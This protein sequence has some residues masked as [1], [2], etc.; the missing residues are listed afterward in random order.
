MPKFNVEVSAQ[1]IATGKWRLRVESEDE[2]T[3]QAEAVS[4]IALLLEAN[5]MAMET[6]G[7]MFKVESIDQSSIDKPANIELLTDTVELATDSGPTQK[8]SA[9]PARQ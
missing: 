3:A 1:Q 2:E 6:E 8:I 7:P 5:E 4:Y 9:L